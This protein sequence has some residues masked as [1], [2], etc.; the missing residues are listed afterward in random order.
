MRFVP[1]ILSSLRLLL[2]L[3]FPMLPERLWIWL[4]LVGAGTDFLDGWLARR[5][6][7]ASWQ[8][9]LLDAVADKAFVL[10]VFLSL[11]GAGKFSPW[12]L[13]ALIARDIMVAVAAGYALILRLWDSF[14]KMDARWSGKIATAG[15]FLLFV[16]ALVWPAAL[17]PVLI[18]AVLVSVVAAL[19][20]GLLF[21]K[22]LAARARQG[23]GEAG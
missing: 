1:N 6:Q 3:A 17:D 4:V 5:F 11:A 19:D 21:G 7:V 22:A 10:S 16:V 23:Q 20:Y 13:P 18:V 12:L 14:Q 9:G 2:A 15:Q 8:G